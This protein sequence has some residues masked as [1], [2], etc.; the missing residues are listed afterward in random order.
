LAEDAAGIAAVARVA[1]G[2]P[3]SSRALS[4]PLSGLPHNERRERP[5]I[6]NSSIGKNIAN[7]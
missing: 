4:L 6:D 1:Q 7:L 3:Q 2:A 5:A